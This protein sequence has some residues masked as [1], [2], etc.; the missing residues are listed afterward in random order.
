MAVKAHWAGIVF[1]LLLLGLMLSR[2]IREWHMRRHPQDYEF[3]DSFPSSEADCYGWYLRQM[4]DDQ[5]PRDP[6]EPRGGQYCAF[7]AQNTPSIP[8]PNFSEYPRPKR[9]WRRGL[10]RSLLEDLP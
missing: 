6:C 2:V 10:Q 8:N 7:A 3:Y 5:P 1:I 9:R 4:L